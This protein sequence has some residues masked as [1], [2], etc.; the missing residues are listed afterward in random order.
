MHPF[1]NKS[2]LNDYCFFFLK[3]NQKKFPLLAAKLLRNRWLRLNKVI[4]S[5]FAFKLRCEYCVPKACYAV[6][7]SLS[8]LLF[9]FLVHCFI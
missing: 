5:L 6:V 7:F 1:V 8:P 3:L 4:E 2:I 9:F